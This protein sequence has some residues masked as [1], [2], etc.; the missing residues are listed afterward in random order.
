MHSGSL[1]T[2]EEMHSIDADAS[3]VAHARSPVGK[4]KEKDVATSGDRQYWHLSVQSIDQ[5]AKQGAV[6]ECQD[7]GTK[8]SILLSVVSTVL[9]AMLIHD[10][11]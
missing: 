4:M 3:T 9:D 6:I 2:N 1:C 11:M 7:I 5:V 8:L 10:S